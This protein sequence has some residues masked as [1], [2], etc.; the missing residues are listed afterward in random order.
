MAR[1]AVRLLRRPKTNPTTRPPTPIPTPTPTPIPIPIQ[2]RFKLYK[3]QIENGSNNSFTAHMSQLML[4]KVWQ[5]ATHDLVAAPTPLPTRSGSRM[6]QP[7][8]VCNVRPLS[9]SWFVGIIVGHVVASIVDYVRNTRRRF[10]ISATRS[11][12][13]CVNAASR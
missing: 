2:A 12:S 6:R 11:L 3:A 9:P 7:V 1:V 13:V 8:H 10:L 4:S 5:E